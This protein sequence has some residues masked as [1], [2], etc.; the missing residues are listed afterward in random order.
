[1]SVKFFCDRCGTEMP[2][3]KPGEVTLFAVD[4]REGKRNQQNQE[5]FQR[6][7]VCRAC[8]TVLLEAAK[9]LPETPGDH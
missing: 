8:H 6:V 3:A 7:E 9:P 2:K 5:T 4:F 1:M